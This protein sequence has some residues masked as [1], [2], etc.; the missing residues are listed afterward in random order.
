MP[1]NCHF[2]DNWLKEE[3]FGGWLTKGN[4][5]SSAFRKMCQKNIDISSMGR[6]AIKSHLK[7]KKHLELICSRSASSTPKIDLFVQRS[8]DSKDKKSLPERNKPSTSVSDNVC[9]DNVCR[10]DV[11]KAETWWC[12]KAIDSNQSFS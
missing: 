9:R 4:T 8:S 1:G 12:L 7:G 5:D 3:E 11:L 2:Q 10:D 6:A